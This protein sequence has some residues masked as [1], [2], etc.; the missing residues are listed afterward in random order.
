MVTKHTDVL[1]TSA[2]C[3]FL[4]WAFD[5]PDMRTAFTASTDLLLPGKTRSGLERMIDGATG[6]RDKMAFE[7]AKWATLNHWGREGVPMAF[8]HAVE[9]SRAGSGVSKAEASGE[10]ET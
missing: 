4:L 5:E 10:G 2:W 9:A 8:W 3:S 1:M 7:F 6:Y